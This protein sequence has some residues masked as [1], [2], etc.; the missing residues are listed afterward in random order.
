LSTSD[1][2]SRPVLLIVDD[3]PDV[4]DALTFMIDVRGF[5]VVHCGTAGEAIALAE[6]DPGYA[7]LVVDQGLPDHQGLD[8]LT[9]LRSRGVTAPAILITTGPSADLRQ[10]ADAAGAPIVEKPLLDDAL[11]T[12]IRRLLAID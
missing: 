8:L 7:C 11:L 3:D 4:L 2:D 10:R 5:R 12:Q 9:M 6:A 1:P